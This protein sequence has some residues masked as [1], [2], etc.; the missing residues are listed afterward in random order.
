MSPRSHEQNE[1]I[2]SKTRETLLKHA[3]EQFA[4][5]GYDGTSIKRIAEAAGVAQGLLYSY[6]PSKE[7]LLKAMFEQSMADVQATFASAQAEADPQARIAALLTAC[8]RTM[9]QNLNFWRV[10]YGVRMQ[11]L[12]LKAIGPKLGAWTR[13]IE[14]TLML[15]LTEAGYPDPEMEA[16]LLFATIDG[17]SQHFALNPKRYPIEEVFARVAERYRPKETP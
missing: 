10:S 1:A 2:R 9:R 4:A 16:R 14:K 5:H 7:A 15:L 13:N 17:V 12:V 3:L 8:A 6:F 11:P